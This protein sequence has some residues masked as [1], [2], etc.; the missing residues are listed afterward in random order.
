MLMNYNIYS[1]YHEQNK[2]NHGKETKATFY[3]QRKLEKPYHIDY[4]FASKKI[5]NKGF[6]IK[7]GDYYDWIGYSDH[8]P[9]I[10]DIKQLFMSFKMTPE[11][12]N[13]NNP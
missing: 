4:C 7:V 2:Q 13:I 6:D 11:E 10:I 1:L 3:M 9:L 5:I 12:S 8:T